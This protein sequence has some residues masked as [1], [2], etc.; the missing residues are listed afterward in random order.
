MVVAGLFDIAIADRAQGAPTSFPS[1]LAPPYQTP[2]SHPRLVAEVDIQRDEILHRSVN[3]E[4]NAVRTGEIVGLGPTILIGPLA[5][6]LYATLLKFFA[7]G[8]HVI[9]REGQMPQSL[10]PLDLES[11]LLLKSHKRPL[12]ITEKGV[13]AAAVRAAAV[14]KGHAQLLC[15]NRDRLIHV[16]NNQIHMIHTL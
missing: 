14:S 5:C 13:F 10:R 16:R 3:L 1:Y 11:W 6:D 8:L 7:C 15:I 4:A 2:G 12:R 9:D